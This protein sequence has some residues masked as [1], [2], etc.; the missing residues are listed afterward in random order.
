LNKRDFAYYAYQNYDKI[1]LCIIEKQGNSK[2]QLY[3]LYSFCINY[4]ENDWELTIKEDDVGLLKDL[5]KNLNI[6]QKELIY[7]PTSLGDH[8]CGV[9][10]LY[11]VGDQYFSPKVLKQLVDYLD[12]KIDINNIL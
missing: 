6:M 10:N 7:K 4:T 1:L 9:N 11:F 12:K 2:L 5:C 3:L 8:I